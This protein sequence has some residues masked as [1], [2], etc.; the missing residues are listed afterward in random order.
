[1]RE[2]GDVELDKVEL[3]AEIAALDAARAVEMALKLEWAARKVVSEAR[4]GMS[5][6]LEEFERVEKEAERFGF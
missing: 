6:A 5:D 3:E 2:V 1:M 4:R